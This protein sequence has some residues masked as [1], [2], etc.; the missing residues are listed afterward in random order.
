MYALRCQVS[1]RGE[2]YQKGGGTQNRI[3]FFKDPTSNFKCEGKDH[4]PMAVF[5]SSLLS[6]VLGHFFLEFRMSSL[7]SEGE[8]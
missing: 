6:R 4:R 8:D 5:V 2:A 7:S 3:L 1:V